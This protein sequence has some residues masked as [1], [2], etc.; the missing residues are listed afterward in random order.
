MQ[1]GDEIRLP[2]RGMPHVRGGRAG[3][4]IVHVK[5]ITPRNLSKRQEELLR[6]LADLDGKNVSPERK[7]WLDRVKDF[8][9]SNPTTG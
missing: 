7:S 6:E 1:H 5:V 9:S 3:D 4:L 2:G 8:F